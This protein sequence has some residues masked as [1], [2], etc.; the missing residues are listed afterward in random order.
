[1]K[2]KYNEHY[3][4][5]SNYANYLERRDRYLKLAQELHGFLGQLCLVNEKST[6]LDYG[7]A[8]GFLMEGFG[9]LGYKNV[10]GYDISQWATAQARKKGLKILDKIEKK[11]FDIIV[12]LDVLE[13]MTNQEIR[14]TFSSF[15]SDIMIVR[16][17]CSLN[18]KRFVLNISNLDQTHLN[19]KT[20][21]AWAK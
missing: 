5:S 18:G 2:M 10:Y 17:P 13:H 16:I 4:K 15:R 1:M 20:G 12:C 21:S 11:S 9:K 19:L 7:C 8:V 14:Q 6:I 3:Y